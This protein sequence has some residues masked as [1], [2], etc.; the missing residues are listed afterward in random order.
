MGHAKYDEQRQ[1]QR[2]KEWGMWE[3][4]DCLNKSLLEDSRIWGYGGFSLAE[5]LLG[6]KKIFL[7][8]SGVCKV[9]FFLLGNVESAVIS[10]T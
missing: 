7:P 4:R 10:G 1:V 8:S 3:R 5:L 6:Q 9:S 2:T